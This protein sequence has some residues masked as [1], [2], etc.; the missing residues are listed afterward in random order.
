[1]L[2][3]FIT[4]FIFLTITGFPI[5]CML[6]SS[7]T[8]I[9]KISTAAYFASLLIVICASMVLR[10]GWDI[11]YSIL[12][13]LLLSLSAWIAFFKKDIKQTVVS[14]SRIK[15]KTI[16]V[17][18]YIIFISSSILIYPSFKGAYALFHMGP[19]FYGYGMSTSY[20]QEQNSFSQLR[21]AIANVASHPGMSTWNLGDLREAVSLDFIINSNRYGL[22]SL[23]ATID[24]TVFHDNS[25]IE[26]LYPLLVI[27]I[28]STLGSLYQL[29]K[30]H[31]IKMVY[32][33]CALALTSFNTTQ[34]VA[35][36]EGH[37]GLVFVLPVSLLLCITLSSLSAKIKSKKIAWSAIVTLVILLTGSL[38]VYQEIIELL[39][40]LLFSL[41][42]FFIVTKDKKNIVNL[43]ITGI[44]FVIVNFDIL[45]TFA[46]ILYARFHQNFA[47]E[48]INVGFLDFFSAVGLLQSYHIVPHTIIPFPQNNSL[49]N[50]TIFIYLFLFI[51]T[52]FY[53]KSRR[54]V[55]EVSIIIFSG[56]F[57]LSIV[58]ARFILK[59][60]FLVWNLTLFLFPFIILSL[61]LL[62]IQSKYYAAI[63][64]KKNYPQIKWKIVLNRIFLVISLIIT[65]VVTVNFIS[66]Y[67]TYTQ[68]SNLLYDEESQAFQ[69]GIYS[70]RIL[71]TMSEN[72]VYYLPG[73]HGHL[74][75]LN[76][77][78]MPEFDKNL[79]R[80]K[81]I[82]VIFK[83]LE[84]ES[85]F[86]N[87]KKYFHK[88]LLYT[89][90]QVII[91]Q[92]NDPTYQFLTKANNTNRDFM[93]KYLNDLRAK[94]NN[95]YK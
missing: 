16:A 17:F 1:M 79:R 62:G 28:I 48:S 74:Y 71:L 50:S 84:N 32:I 89:N 87:A 77:G 31:K 24:N 73:F 86:N 29:L 34:L 57:F 51:T 7:T 59:S 2:I 46:F 67:K 52:L 88:D 37:L 11:N 21:H 25:A 56:I 53:Y 4:I 92:L 36:T 13:F 94:V 23:A 33:L 3:Q 42:I 20:L 8:F 69:K 60:D 68:N 30:Q 47:G 81:V 40:L 26:L 72:Q 76:S 41:F 45:V 14:L 18:V 10:L 64:F 75:W 58:A 6:Y 95:R 82:L 83:Q 15:L 65:L 9:F 44:F 85:F 78:W 38:I 43:L 19:D 27:A 66:L 5:I 90:D 49:A 80:Q 61:I 93:H 54:I 35:I 39:F 12:P 22:Q 55:N 70:N 91:A 63:F